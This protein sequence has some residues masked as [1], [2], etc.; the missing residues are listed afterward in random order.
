MSAGWPVWLVDTVKA[1]Y[2][3]DTASQASS[4]TT[5]GSASSPST[6]STTPSLKADTT[7]NGDATTSSTT[8]SSTTTSSTTSTPKFDSAFDDFVASTAKIHV[9]NEEQSRDDFKASVKKDVNK[10]ATVTFSDAVGV[11]ELNGSTV[12][13]PEASI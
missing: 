13:D 2:T 4:T 3:S 9:N 5:N 11:P 8:T 6:D 12:A 1:L 7:S 10:S